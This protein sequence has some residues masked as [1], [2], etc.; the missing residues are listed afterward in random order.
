[1]THQ[2]NPATS[3]IPKDGLLILILSDV[4]YERI[5]HGHAENFSQI[6]EIMRATN[7]S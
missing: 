3:K 2:V 4:S 7:Q 6:D 5:I 1:M